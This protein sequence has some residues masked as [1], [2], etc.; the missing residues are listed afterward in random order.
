MPDTT[1]RRA[2]TPGAIPVVAT[3]A[4][5]PPDPPPEP[6]RPSK[7]PRGPIAIVVGGVVDLAAI[8]AVMVLV[9][10][11]HLDVTVAVV[12]IGL[13]AGVRVTDL[14]SG[15]TPP[16]GAAPLLLGSLSGAALEIAH[17]LLGGSPHA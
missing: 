17:R 14:V 2:H 4:A 16:G 7:P 6:E 5:P 9:L 15:R 8:V 11:A 1:R 13:L 12:L 10:R 3:P